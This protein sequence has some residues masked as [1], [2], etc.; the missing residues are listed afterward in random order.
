MKPLPEAVKTVI[1]LCLEHL[2]LTQNPNP[3]NT[4]VPL[5]KVSPSNYDKRITR[6]KTQDVEWKNSSP[7]TT[8]LHL[9]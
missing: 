9:C 6:K 4:I 7:S 2:T 8:L 1:K 3:R 5:I